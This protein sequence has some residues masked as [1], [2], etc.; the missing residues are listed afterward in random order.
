MD[1]I[2]LLLQAVLTAENKVGLMLNVH[3]KNLQE[4]LNILPA[5]QQP[6]VAHLSDPEWFSL[7][8]VLDS[9]IMRDIIPALKAAG[10]VGLVEY[11]LN[12]VVL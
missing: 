4:V 5:L 3:Q 10:A 8:T 9:H 2:A 7:T 11:T 12:K 1:G 6:T